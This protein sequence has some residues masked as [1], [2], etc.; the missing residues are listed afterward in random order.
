MSWED[1]FKSWS[2][3]PS[4]T[5][6]QKMENAETAIRKAIK[7]NK[8][9][10]DMDITIIPQGS[11]RARTNVRLD[12]D[13]DICIYLNSTFFPRYPPG[14]TKEDY[15]NIDGSISFSNYKNLVY[16]ALGEYFSWENVD[17]GNKAFDIHSNTYRVDADVVPAFAYRYYKGNG[18]DNYIQPVGIAFDTVNKGRI[19]NWPYQSYENGKAKHERTGRRYKKMVRIVKRLRNKM[20]EAGISAAHGIGS[21]LIESSVWN[22]P[23]EGFNH[24]T[25]TADV[26]YVIADCFNKTRLQDR[27]GAMK[28][29]NNIKLLFGDHQPWT[30]EQAHTFFSAA[31]EY[32]GFE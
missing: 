9:L 27:Y 12:S 32:L 4:A 29:V 14:K 16:Q 23:A 24:D 26:R 11:Y 2:A 3:A 30:P 21:F 22:V 20:Q 7:A 13:V 10:A 8:D 28:E 31:W 25:Y 15:G 1:T 19:I 17:R 6:Q 18:W 5:E